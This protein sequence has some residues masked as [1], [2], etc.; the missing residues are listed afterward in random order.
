MARSKPL[1]VLLWAAVVLLSAGLVVAQ[2]DSADVAGLLTFPWCQC[3]T[4]SCACSPYKLEIVST[5]TVGT[6]TTTCLSVYEIGCDLS[7]ACCRGMRGAIDKISFDST[8]KCGNKTAFLNVTLD[9]KRWVSW[10]VIP[11]NPGFDF[12]IY[13]LNRNI[14]SFPGS[15]ICISSRAPCST[16]R[17][18]PSPQP[19]PPLPPSPPPKKRKAP[20]PMLPPSPLPPSPPPPCAADIYIHLLAPLVTGG[21]Y[22]FN[23][24]ICAG[25][26]DRISADL[27]AQANAVGSVIVD[28][29]D[30]TTC[31]SSYIKVSG[32]FRG[33]YDG[34][35]LET[36]LN[37]PSGME[38]W[39]TAITGGPT[40]SPSLAGPTHN[41]PTPPAPPSPN[42]P[43]PAP[44]CSA[45]FIIS[46]TPPASLVGPMFTF[47]DAMC[48]Q[49]TSIISSSVTANATALGA[50]IT[51]PF[52]SIACSKTYD[53]SIRPPV[54]PF[55][56]VCGAFRSAESGARLQAFLEGPTGL[57]SWVQILTGGE[58]CFAT[59]T[60]YY[61]LGEVVDTLGG[62]TCLVSEYGQDCF[63]PPPRPPPSPRP[64]APRP[65]SPPL[66]CET[67]VSVSLMTMDNI[68]AGLPTFNVSQCTSIA[69]RIG[70][71]FAAAAPTY[72]SVITSGFTL[73]SCSPLNVVLR[74][75]FLSS[76]D[77]SRMSDWLYGP[78]GMQGWMLSI[79]GAPLCNGLSTYSVFMNVAG[80][81]GAS[82]LTGSLLQDCAPGFG[83]PSPPPPKLK[84]RTPPPAQP[85][86]L[87]P[88]LLSSPSPPPPASP[89]LPPPPSPMPSPTHICRTATTNVPYSVGPLYTASTKDQNGDAAVAMCTNVFRE[90][91]STGT[92]CGMDFAKIEVPVSNACKADLRRLTINGTPFAYT[93]G[94]YPDNLTTIKFT[95]LVTNLP[96]PVGGTMCWVV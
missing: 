32:S 58:Q 61:F 86:T 64:P 76:F 27:A 36:W 9:G 5:K 52:I 31:D 95:S 78:T 18:P 2:E 65:P 79:F 88:Q 66:A 37:S 83:Q 20:P 17:P 62:A 71:S 55:V 29:F 92:C 84:K 50:E 24:A 87:I 46:I 43:S 26:A 6:A 73:A 39:V 35:L 13:N 34:K 47:T 14:S 3:S 23:D 16:P 96:N 22:T 70:S 44:P 1:Q 67:L 69:L 8:S 56:K 4:Y 38:S 75:S 77:G 48:S 60:G 49:L 85:P 45:C 30:L 57:R 33:P 54:L 80:A 91:C 93:W 74:G 19:P 63:Q 94:L 82:C 42:P 59:L 28:S 51:S 90:T 7:S 81:N 53:G 12:K 72:G 25:L 89:P 11:R 68:T 10:D 40:C 21:P 15:V 41:G